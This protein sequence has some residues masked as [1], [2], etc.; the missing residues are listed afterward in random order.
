MVESNKKSKKGKKLHD[1]P[2]AE[3]QEEAKQIETGDKPKG[4]FVFVRQSRE[5]IIK[6][7]QKAV[8]A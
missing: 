7:Q 3:N 5:D 2:A 8:N 1:K 6:E 4:E